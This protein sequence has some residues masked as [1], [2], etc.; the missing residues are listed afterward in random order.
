MIRPAGTGFENDFLGVIS[1]GCAM[2]NM[3]LMAHSLGIGVHI[4]SSLSGNEVEERD[5]EDAQHSR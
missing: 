3:W 5:Y 2:E 4:V 1:L